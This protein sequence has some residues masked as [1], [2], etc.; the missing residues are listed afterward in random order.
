[1][2]DRAEASRRATQAVEAVLDRVRGRQAPV[3]AANYAR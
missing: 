1:V 2:L 3:K